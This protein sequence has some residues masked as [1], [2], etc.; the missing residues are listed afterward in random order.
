M[1]DLHTE[2]YKALLGDLKNTMKWK[3]ILCTWMGRINIVKISTLPKA[4][5]RLN[6]IPIKI[7]MA[8]TKEREQKSSDLYGTTKDPK[9][10]KQS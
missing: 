1:K 8:C 4:I 2:N 3:D 7:A 5:Y 10:L 6:A 9:L